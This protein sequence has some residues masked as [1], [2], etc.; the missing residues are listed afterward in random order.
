MPRIGP[1]R[2]ATRPRSSVRRRCRITPAKSKTCSDLPFSGSLSREGAQHRWCMYHVENGRLFIQSRAV[3]KVPLLKLPTPFGLRQT[4][5][6]CLI[7]RK[8]YN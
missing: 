5:R 8:Q 2:R 1:V 3:L 4:D 6:L 7:S